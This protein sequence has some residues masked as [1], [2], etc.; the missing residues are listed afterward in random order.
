MHPYG[1]R[2]EPVA[3]PAPPTQ[4]RTAAAV[5]ADTSVPD[6]VRKCAAEM[7]GA[8]DELAEARTR[9]SAAGRAGDVV[10]AYA[11]GD[12]AATLTGRQ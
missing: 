4:T 10:L 11:W 12:V 1:R 3:P 9:A 7:A 8:A 6:R 5:A 2:D